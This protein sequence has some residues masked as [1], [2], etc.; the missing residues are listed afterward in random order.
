[1]QEEAR[2]SSKIIQTGQGN[3]FINNGAIP[4]LFERNNVVLQT[5]EGPVPYSSKV[6]VHRLLPEVAGTGNLNITVGGANS[7]AQS[8]TYGSTQTVAIQTDSPWVGTTQNIGAYD[9][10]QSRV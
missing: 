10:C 8:A 6:Y 5:E 7:T 4:A 1:M 3:S 2:P 9:F